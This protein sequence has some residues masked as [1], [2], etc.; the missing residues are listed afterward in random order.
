MSK[1]FALTLTAAASAT[2]LWSMGQA[3][4]IANRNEFINFARKVSLGNT[5]KGVTVSLWEDI[6]LEGACFNPIGGGKTPFMGKFD[7]QGHKISNLDMSTNESSVGIFGTVVSGSISNIIVDDSCKITSENKSGDVYVGGIAGTMAAVESP[8]YITNCVNMADLSAYGTRRSA[9]GGLLGTL[10]TYGE[11]A[12]LKNCANFGETTIKTPGTMAGGILGYGMGSLTRVEINNCLNHGNIQWEANEGNNAGGIVGRISKGNLINCVNMGTIME[13]N[14][15]KNIGELCGSA[16]NTNGSYCYCKQNFTPV[17][18]NSSTISVTYFDENFNIQNSSDSPFK[19]LVTALNNYSR[20]HKVNEWFLNKDEKNVNFV[21]DTDEIKTDITFSSKLVL[22]PKTIGKGYHFEGWY[23]NS[24]FTEK[25][26]N[27]TVSN[28]EKLYGH[29]EKCTDVHTITF[30]TGRGTNLGKIQAKFGETVSL[31]HESISKKEVIGLWLDEYGERVSWQY[32]MPAEDVTLYAK[33][34]N[35][36]L[37]TREDF[38]AFAKNVNSGV[39]FTNITISLENDIDMFGAEE[40]DPIGLAGNNFEGTFDG[41]GHKISNLV[42]KSTYPRAGLFGYS[43]KG[44]AVR[45]VIIDESCTIKGNYSAINQLKDFVT[46]ATGGVIGYCMSR[47]LQCVLENTINAGTVEFYGSTAETDSYIGGLVG[48]FGSYLINSVIRNSLFMGTIKAEGI[49]ESGGVGGIIG[50]LKGSSS[51]SPC[52]IENS[53]ISGKIIFNGN[54]TNQLGIGGIAGSIYENSIVQNSLDVGEFEINP[55]NGS[56]TFGNITG[57]MENVVMK[58]CYWLGTNNYGYGYQSSSA[59]ED[60][61]SFGADFNL[62]DKVTVSNTYNGYSLIGALNAYTLGANYLS[63]WVANVN[64]KNVT[65]KFNNNNNNSF[66]ANSMVILL[67]SFVS[68]DNSDFFGWYEDPEL[69][70]LFTKKDIS[71]TST[72]YGEWGM[73]ENFIVTFIDNG[74]VVKNSTVK[75]GDT[76]NLDSIKLSRKKHSFVGWLDEYG[77]LASGEYSMPKRNVTFTTL[78]VKTSLQ[79]PEDLRKFSESVGKGA[80]CH[81]KTVYLD[82][83]IDMA[84]VIGFEPIGNNEHPF[85][86]TFEGN[87]Y[88]VSNLQIRTTAQYSGLFGNGFDITIKNVL[89]DGDSLVENSYPLGYGCTG[90]I[91][92]YCGAENAKCAIVNAVNYANIVVK[93]QGSSNTINFGGIIG[94]CKGFSQMCYIVNC[95]NF[96]SVSH[97]GTTGTSFIGGIVGRCSSW[98]RN[99]PCTMWNNINYGNISHRGKTK[100]GRLG[101]GGLIGFCDRN[102][103]LS[104]CVSVGNISLG[105]KRTCVGSIFGKKE[106]TSET[107][108]NIWFEENDHGDFDNG[109]IVL[110]KN[111]TSENGT[112][113]VDFLRMFVSSKILTQSEWEG[114]E[115]VWASEEK[116]YTSTWVVNKLNKNITVKINGRTVAVYNSSIVLLPTPIENAKYT[117]GGWKRGN[118]KVLTEEVYQDTVYSG[119]W[120]RVNSPFTIT[121]FCTIM[122]SWLFVLISIVAVFYARGYNKR[123]KATRELKRFIYPKV[124]EGTE[125]ITS[126]NNI[127]GLYPKD[128]ERPTMEDALRN[129]GLNDNQIRDIT[130]TCYKHAYELKNSGKLPRD[131][132]V[133]DAATIAM[134]TFDFGTSHIKSNPYS[135]VNFALNNRTEERVNKIKDLLY[136]IISALRKLPIVH[137]IY[138]YR[139]IRVDVSEKLASD[140]IGSSGT[141]DLNDP[142]AF[143]SRKDGSDISSFEYKEGSIIT[144]NALSSTSPSMNVTKNFLASGLSTGKAAGTLFIMEN[145]WGYDIQPYSLYPTES[146]ILLEPERQ[147]QVVSVIP[148]ELTIVKLRMLKTFIVL[149]DVYGEHKLR[150]S[151]VYFITE[152]TSKYMQRRRRQKKGLLG[153]L[154]DAQAGSGRFFVKPGDRQNGR[155]MGQKR[156]GDRQRTRSTNIDGDDDGYDYFDDDEFFESFNDDEDDM[157]K[158]WNELSDRNGKQTATTQDA[159]TSNSTITQKLI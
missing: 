73:R 46:I 151:P 149:P 48:Y 136:L 159:F 86:G 84:G 99:L 45:N 16:E 10:I 144:W 110:D 36:S 29:Y 85:M 81:N 83:D 14:D 153:F 125:I 41:K 25:F 138:L 100:E 64:R 134:Y 40:I 113:A 2:L 141:D 23:K 1:R 145:C 49:I 103:R 155:R 106:S 147:F 78:W 71:D 62:K 17:G 39:G 9:V 89:L 19:L 92:G 43:S 34:A 122:G 156:R 96:G 63:R 44:M 75:P 143:A 111:L 82:D 131:I 42:I 7:G 115:A 74:K 123:V 72:L 27:E 119:T 55:A 97:Q 93:G 67:T 69:T 51:Y 80:S 135:L 60:S 56:A 137:G 117:F 95:V 22:S 146:E 65:F 11:K 4:K 15:T 139:G 28:D 6:D 121:L 124:S 57:I 128:Y 130:G 150:V 31:P 30:E 116:N 114:G 66:T 102:N 54:T 53:M 129:A 20:S 107:R 112:A 142:N 50:C 90:G 47:E 157:N 12:Y 61:V 108:D 109:N 5:Y 132:T 3:L 8:T 126:L 13:Q 94:L 104:G 118:K 70:I 133:D 152:K 59:V 98:K 77:W 24:A 87:G 148:A 91:L 127:G 79:T 76:I 105:D 35:V 18:S 68:G 38:I 101:V 21:V 52:A 32:T 33:W 26:D 88:R 37:N 140:S 158:E 154:K 120:D 58:N